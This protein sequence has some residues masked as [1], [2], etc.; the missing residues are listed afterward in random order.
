VQRRGRPEQG[1]SRRKQLHVTGARTAKH[2]SRQH[3]RQAERAAKQRSAQSDRTELGEGDADA[4]DQQGTGQRV[5]NTSRSQI[6]DC[7]ETRA[8]TDDGQRENFRG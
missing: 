1:A 3:E 5:R 2:V 6:D 8:R 7:S 4:N